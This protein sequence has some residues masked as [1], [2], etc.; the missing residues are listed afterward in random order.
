MTKNLKVFV[1]S[2]L[3]ALFVNACSNR[4]DSLQLPS[5]NLGSHGNYGTGPN[6]TKPYPQREKVNLNGVGGAKVIYEPHS[7][8]GNKNY[9]VL[10]KNYQVWKNF[11]SYI[12][13]GTASWY[14]PGFH[15]KKT[16]N[17]EVYDQRGF[18]AAHKNL[19]L[20]SY[21]KV[22]NLENNKQIVVRVN[23]RG[24]FH[25]NRIIDLSEGAAKAINMTGKGT[26][27]V[28]L[29]YLNVMPNGSIANARG[30][31]NGSG[32]FGGSANNGLDDLISDIQQGK[33]P[34][35]GTIVGATFDVINANKKPNTYTGNN[36]I[37]VVST[38]S[39]DKAKAIKKAFANR[40]SFPVNI[41]Q[42]GNL[43]RVR[44]GPMP[45]GSLNSQLNLAKQLGYRDSFIKRL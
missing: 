32:S 26:A 30:H 35:I 10:G 34:T 44:I 21:V 42:E 6:N 22:T 41:L 12:E 25:G 16:S 27:R 36:Y 4:D 38:I 31:Y 17:G 28:K 7:R 2:I 40:T 45:E 1:V 8:G 15:S 20:P 13:V 14:G 39:Y 43:Y 29:E 11:N 23:D 37:Q 24:P 3:V 33:K 19:P 18:S 5:Y 9:T